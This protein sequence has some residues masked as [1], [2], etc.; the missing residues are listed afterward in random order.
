MVRPHAVHHPHRT[1]ASI[2]FLPCFVVLRS[3]PHPVPA[4]QHAV[5]CSGH[6]AEPSF[7]EAIDK[8]LSSGVQESREALPTV[9]ASK[10]ELA[11]MGVKQLKTIL[12]DRK[13][14][15]AGVTEKSELVDL[16]DSQCRSIT[17]Y[18]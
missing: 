13:L 1:S 14:S 11:A 3:G 18:K 7:E 16:V 5:C 6:P 9:T 17:Y 2:G 15:Y 10:E 12:D 4:A 8:A